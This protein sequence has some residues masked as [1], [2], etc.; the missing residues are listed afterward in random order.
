[1]NVKKIVLGTMLT[2]ALVATSPSWTARAAAADG[3]AEQL[4]TVTSAMNSIPDV[5]FYKDLSG[6]YRGGNTA[7]GALVGKPVAEIVGKTDADLFPAAVAKSFRENDQAML[8]SGKSRSNEETLV[9]PDGR[10]V[11]VDTTKTP[12]VGADGKVI[13]VLGICHAIRVGGAAGKGEGK[14]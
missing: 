12:W 8:A 4:A 3:T 13:G 7:W 11:L 6:V 5:V 14:N 10:K 9:Y 1:M 2:A